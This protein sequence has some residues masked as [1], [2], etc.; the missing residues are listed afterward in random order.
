MEVEEVAMPTMTPNYESVVPHALAALTPS[1]HEMELAALSSQHLGA[2]AQATG[3]VQLTVTDE[4]GVTSQAQIPAA[5]L[6]LLFA[7]LSEMSSGNAVALLP[8]S[9][10]LTTQQ[11]ADIL[12]VSRPYLVGLLENGHIPFRKVGVQRRVRLQNLMDY[13]RR[14]DVERRAALD[15]MARQAQELRLGYDE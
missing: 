3:D 15:D 1:T 4:G 2:F 14:T 13:K 5:A 8:L 10:E 9:A 6:R 7:A 12:N 11:A